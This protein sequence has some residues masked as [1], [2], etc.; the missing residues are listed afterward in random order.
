M[1]YISYLEIPK[2]NLKEE[3]ICPKHKNKYEYFCYQCNEKYCDKCLVICNDSS[4]IHEDHLI[5]RLDQLEKNRNRINETMEEFQKLKQTNLK[6]DHLIK[7]YELKIRELEI[8]KNN[9]ISEIDLIKEEKNKDINNNIHSLSDNYNIIRSKNDEIANSIDTTP[10]ALQNIIA[11]K[12][13]GQGKQIYEHL[14]SLNEY[15]KNN[16]FINLNIII[17]NLF[18]INFSFKDFI[19]IIIFFIIIFVINLFI[20]I[21][22]IF[23]EKISNIINNWNFNCLIIINFFSTKSALVLFIQP[24]C[25]TIFTSWSITIFTHSRFSEFCHTNITF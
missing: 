6:I 14:L 18:N 23:H 12:D 11:F 10:M 2:L 13:H 8:E 19:I 15:A 16:N 24:F 17:E 21:I 5:I 3:D 25:N 7:L 22:N 4:K 1:N 20:L 9:F